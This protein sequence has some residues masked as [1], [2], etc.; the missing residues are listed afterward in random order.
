MRTRSVDSPPGTRSISA[1]VA[2]AWMVRAPAD[3]PARIVHQDADV[4]AFHDISPQAPTHLL[5]IPRRHIGSL[6]DSLE[7]DKAL[8]GQYRNW[9]EN[10]QKLQIQRDR[11]S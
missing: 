4:V 9:L 2:P 1:G 6:N 11:E 5:V 3:R 10:Q 7:N 8:L